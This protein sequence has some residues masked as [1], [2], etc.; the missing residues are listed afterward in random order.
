MNRAE[1][2]RELANKVQLSQADVDSVISSLEE[3]L[4]E[5]LPTT[6]KVTLRSFGDFSLVN[7]KARK[8]RNPKTGEPVDVPAK[9]VVKF[10]PAKTFLERFNGTSN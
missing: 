10:R 4:I 3:V 6:K 5:K 2:I 1:L 8:A 7:K 9:N